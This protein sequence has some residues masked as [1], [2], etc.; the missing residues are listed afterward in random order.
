[1]DTILQTIK[2]SIPTTVWLI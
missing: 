2:C 1:M